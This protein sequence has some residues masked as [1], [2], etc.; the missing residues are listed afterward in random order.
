[1]IE[2]LILDYNR[3]KELEELLLSIDRFCK[4]KKKVVV[5]NNGGERYADVHQTNR[6]ID[7]VIHNQINVGCG[8]GTIQL[9][10]QCESDYA[11]YIQVDHEL[12]A[13]IYQADIKNMVEMLEEKGF[14]YI[15]C[16]GD[17][18]QGKYSERAQFI[19]RNYYLSIP[20]MAGGPGALDDLKW[21]E[22]CVQEAHPKFFTIRLPNGFPPFI[23][24]GKDSVRSNPDGSQWK[25][26]P[27]T[28]VV[29][30]LKK[31]TR[32]FTFPPLTD[33][34]WNLAIA[35][36]WP[37]EGYIPKA[38]ADNSFEVWNKKPK[39]ESIFTCDAKAYWERYHADEITFEEFKD[40]YSYC[41]HCDNWDLSKYGPCI[42]YAR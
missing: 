12:I 41:S 37:K 19:N 38:W 27:D 15:D 36:K 2:I 31:P 20:K 18:G 30:C 8:L 1:M 14:D 33:N 28:K 23:D 9:F 4:F 16:A 42:C 29:Y 11:F 39:Q 34:E 21:T 25:H 35:G 17:Q 26:H 40:K 10:S 13:P 22:E 5:L 6:L 3:P 32:K 24:K 7:K